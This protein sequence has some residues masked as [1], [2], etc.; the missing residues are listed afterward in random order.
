MR[1]WESEDPIDDTILREDRLP[2]WAL[3]H[4]YAA[5]EDNAPVYVDIGGYP[6]AIV[7]EPTIEANAFA[8]V[9][10]AD[11]VTH[12]DQCL[13]ALAQDLLDAPGSSVVTRRQRGI[14]A[15]LGNPD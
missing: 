10:S 13:R 14:N 9:L 2:I 15:V 4:R 12:F 11:M 1:V 8:A 7:C 3:R 5:I 6:L